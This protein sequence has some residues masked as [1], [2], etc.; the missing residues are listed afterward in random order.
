[1]IASNVPAC[2]IPGQLPLGA[3]CGAST[4]CASGFCRLPETSFCGKCAARA[5]EGA[6]CDSD[7]ACGPSLLCNDVA[8]CTKPSAVGAFCNETHP[9][10]PGLAYCSFDNTCQRYAAEGKSCNNAGPTAAQP[11]NWGLACRPMEGGTCMKIKYVAAGEKCG[12]PSTPGGVPVLCLGSASCVSGTCKPAG[13][14]D[15]PCTASPL[16]DAAGC[17]PPALCLAGVCK[18]PDPASCK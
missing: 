13:A 17:V 5:P 15:A 7:D 12:L 11:C 4:Q 6:E 3:A 8:H 14:D 1:V 10:L 18:L 9:C 2:E 16:G